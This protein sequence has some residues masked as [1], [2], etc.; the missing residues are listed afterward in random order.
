MS[1]VDLD[2]ARDAVF[3][4][5]TNNVPPDAIKVQGPNFDQPIELLGLLKS[6]ERIG[7]QATGLSRAIKIV[8]EMVCVGQ[9]LDIT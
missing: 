2:T 3:A 5:R 7:F 1:T 9:G 4:T 6:Y 8:E